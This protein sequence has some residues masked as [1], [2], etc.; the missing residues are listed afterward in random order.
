[1]T[2]RSPMPRTIRGACHILGINPDEVDSLT[3]A[4]VI[5]QHETVTRVMLSIEQHP[6]VSDQVDILKKTL[7][8]A[9]IKIVS[10]LEST[11]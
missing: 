10:W 8:R 5:K 2:A 9:R 4:D 3:A 6:E 11:P 1:M 7:N